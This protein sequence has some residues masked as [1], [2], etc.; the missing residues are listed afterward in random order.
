MKNWFYIRDDVFLNLDC[1]WSIQI[2]GNII[3][4]NNKTDN[5]ITNVPVEKI[6]ELKQLLKNNQTLTE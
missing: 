6:E 5:K 4:V 1:I 3:Y 2:S